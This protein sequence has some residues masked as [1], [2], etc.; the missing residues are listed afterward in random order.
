MNKSSQTS[1]IIEVPPALSSSWVSKELTKL[2]T[3][4]LVTY[5]E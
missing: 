3:D 2:V 1:E 4:N 5:D